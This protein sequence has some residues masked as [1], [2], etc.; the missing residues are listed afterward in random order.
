MPQV[1]VNGNMLYYREIGEGP[2]ALFV[3]GFPLDHGVWFD[4]MRGLAHVR[5]CIAPDLRGFGRSDPVV[6]QTLTMEMLADDMIQVVEALRIGPVDLVALSMGGYVALALLELRP[7]LVRS[8]ALVATRAGA[9][10]VEARAGRDA[11]AARILDDGRASLA[12]ELMQALLGRDPT[13]LAQ[14]RLRSM[15]ESTRYETLLGAIEGIKERRDRRTVLGR[16]TVPAAVIGGDEDRLISLDEIRELAAGIP[17]ARLV[18]VPGSGHLVPI[19]HPEPVSQ[20]LLELFQ[21]RKVVWPR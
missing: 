16:I 17:G 3:H 6:D 14:A 7:D 18:I 8:V 15:V 10:G 1:R 20:A 2:A 21:G 9:D 12:D 4:Q 5:R 11:M 13:R 19:E